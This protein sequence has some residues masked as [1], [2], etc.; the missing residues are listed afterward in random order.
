MTEIAGEYLGTITGGA[1]N[2]IML[3]RELGVSVRVPETARFANE[4]RQMLSKGTV[5]QIYLALRLA[6]VRVFSNSGESIPMLLDD[7]FANYDDDRLRNAL[8]L[9]RE[10]SKTN[11]IILFTCRDDVAKAGSKIG[12]EPIAL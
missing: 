1:Y 11:Q 4:P 10:V 5:D 7:P 6:L 12:V 8:E 3:N 2:E 9:L